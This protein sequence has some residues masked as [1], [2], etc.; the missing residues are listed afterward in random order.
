M[1]G[2]QAADD[3]LIEARALRPF[4]ERPML[5]KTVLY[6]EQPDIARLAAFGEVQRP[7]VS[8]L[9]VAKLS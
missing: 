3:K 4:Y 6:F 8:D 1:P 2:A 5:G 9:F 7:S